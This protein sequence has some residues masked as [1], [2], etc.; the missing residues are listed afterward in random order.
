MK[1]LQGRM[2]RSVAALIPAPYIS[3]LAA[4][5]KGELRN[6]Y[7]S[8]HLTERVTDYG[9]EPGAHGRRTG[10]DDGDRGGRAGTCRSGG[11]AGIEAWH[12]EGD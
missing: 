6:A 8:K 5:A 2:D 10:F 7:E 1:E 3:S 12:G 9:P 11:S 4:W